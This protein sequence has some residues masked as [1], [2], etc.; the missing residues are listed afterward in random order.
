MINKNG[1]LKCQVNNIENFSIAKFG[2]EMTNFNKET[3]KI[4][5]TSIN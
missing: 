2:F 5:Y 4:F 3:I 1:H